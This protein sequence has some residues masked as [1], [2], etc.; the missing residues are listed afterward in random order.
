MIDAPPFDGAWKLTVTLPLPGLTDGV[1]G[2]DGLVAMTTFDEGGENGPAPLTFVANTRHVYVLPAVSGNTVIG[3]ARPVTD[4]DA[5]PFEDVQLA[6]KSVI[7]VPLNGGTKVTRMVAVPA[8]TVGAA[9][10]SGTVSGTTAADG[11]DWGPS[12][13]ALVANTVQV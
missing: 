6:V 1:A 4:P 7:G 2:R 9:G 10:A 11:T 12:P 8:R 13:L 3:D 5:P